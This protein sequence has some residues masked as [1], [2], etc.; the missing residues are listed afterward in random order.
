MLLF[1]RYRYA[2]VFPTFIGLF[3]FTCN[4]HRRS[5]HSPQTQPPN[6]RFMEQQSLWGNQCSCSCL[7]TSIRCSR[8]GSKS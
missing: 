6:C 5:M 2:I 4:A 3:L 8:R 7:T 1:F